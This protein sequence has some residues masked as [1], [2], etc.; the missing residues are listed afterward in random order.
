M[1]VIIRKMLQL[2]VFLQMALL[3]VNGGIGCNVLHLVAMGLK[4]EEDN[5][6]TCR[7]QREIKYG[8]KDTL[9]L[10]IVQVT[11]HVQ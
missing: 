9:I 7:I 8:T 6:K 10:M 5:V 1:N 4:P 3:V 11:Y 2:F